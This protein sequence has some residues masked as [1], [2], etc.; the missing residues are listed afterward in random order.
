MNRKQAAGLI[1]I[2]WGLSGRQDIIS[3]NDKYDLLGIPVLIYTFLMVVLM[4]F[5]LNSF[6]DE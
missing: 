5:V 1:I 3:I 2:M 4:A 6:E